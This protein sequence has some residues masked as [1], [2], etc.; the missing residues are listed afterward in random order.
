MAIVYVLCCGDCLC[1]VLGVG[2]AG[3]WLAWSCEGH[4]RIQPVL[5]WLDCS[6]VWD[7]CRGAVCCGGCGRLHWP[8]S[9]AHIVYSRTPPRGWFPALKAGFEF[10]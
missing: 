9:K 8:A 2:G 10:S 4:M 6:C 5:V 7:T 3:G 1:I